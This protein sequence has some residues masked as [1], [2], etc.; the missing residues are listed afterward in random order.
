MPEITQTV[1]DIQGLI[2]ALDA[3]K[4][5]GQGVLSGRNFLF[6]LDGPKSAF[7]NDYLIPFVFLNPNY[8]QGFRLRVLEQDLAIYFFDQ[9]M[10][11]FDP[12]LGTFKILFEYQS[13]KLNPHRWTWGAVGRFIFFCHPVV[14]I[15][16][17]S[18]DLQSVN[19]HIGIGAP[20]KPI[21]ITA[22]NG[23]LVILDATT[24]YWSKAENGFNF[25]PTLGEAGF[26]IVNQRITGE[27]IICHSYGGG[28]VTFTTAGFMRSEFTGDQAIYRHRAVM[29]EFHP[30]NSFCTFK[31][32]NST[33]VF[34]ARQGLYQTD[35]QRPTPYAQLF[36]EFLIDE[37]PKFN[38]LGAAN[39]RLEWD[40]EARHLFLSVSVTDLS[41]V[42]EKAYVYYPANDKFGTFDE[43]HYGIFPINII[44]GARKTASFGFMD[45]TGR[46]RYW[47][48]QGLRETLPTD[49]TGYYYK[50]LVQRPVQFARESLHRVMP[51]VARVAHLPEATQPGLEIGGGLL[52]YYDFDGSTLLD[53]EVEGLDS[54]VRVGL[55]R[56]SD[57]LSNDEFSEV[58]GISIGS[59]ISGD[60]AVD[61]LDFNIVPDGVSDEDYNTAIGGEDFGVDRFTFINFDLRLISSA[62]GQKAFNICSPDLAHFFDS[63]RYYRCNSIGIYHILEFHAN[64]PGQFYHVRSLEISAINAGVLI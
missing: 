63:Q 31:F 51:S 36:N 56:F 10:I 12:N 3:R 32:D 42:Y 27:P 46:L 34:L 26:Q 21:A 19:W 16:A 55:F 38:L 37:L 48:F 23:R 47:K 29:T 44:G 20:A 45:L 59:V 60:V 52:G 24:L 22:D 4:T 6:D 15:L 54:I 11:L 57:L 53:R 14:G 64:T 17:Y 5:Q 41:A 40:D 13:T 33:I 43:S 8:F 30:I 1:T 9:E 18:I 7:G 50:P 58:Q 49:P 2:P 61:S 39:L 62:D 35:S 25:T 28:I